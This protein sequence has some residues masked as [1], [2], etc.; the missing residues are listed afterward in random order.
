MEAGA[1]VFATPKAWEKA[2]LAPVRGPELAVPASK[3]STL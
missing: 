1:G 2:A 3:E